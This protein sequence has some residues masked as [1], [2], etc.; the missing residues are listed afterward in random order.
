MKSLEVVSHGCHRQIW[1]TISK[2][3]P[4]DLSNTMRVSLDGHPPPIGCVGVSPENGTRLTHHQH[5][6]CHVSYDPNPLEDNYEYVNPPLHPHQIS[7]YNETL[8]GIKEPRL[9][10]HCVSK[11]VRAGLVICHDPNPV[12]ED[13]IYHTIEDQGGQWYP[14][15]DTPVSLEG[16]P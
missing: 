8:I 1:S 9:L 15:S 16:S 7:E 13:W 4:L 3:H 10:C 12:T 14:L 11:T 5:R 2:H 6:L